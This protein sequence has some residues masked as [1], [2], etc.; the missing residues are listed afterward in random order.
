MQE[1]TL[2]CS[3]TAEE[4]KGDRMSASQATEPRVAKCTNLQRKQRHGLEA[5][6]REDFA[7][8]KV[9]G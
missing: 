7:S 5:P 2:T 8:A 1:R 3:R 6:R 9:S 4:T